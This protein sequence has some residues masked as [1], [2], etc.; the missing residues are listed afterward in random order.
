MKDFKD[1]P[2][3]V[4]G[5]PRLAWSDGESEMGVEADMSALG[6]DVR[7][8]F[9][10]LRREWNGRPL[11]YLDTASTAQKPEIVMDALADHLRRVN[12]NVHR[13]VYALAREADAAYDEA[14][15]WVAGFVGGDLATT[16]F[17]KNVTEAINL[18][19]YAWGRANIH[20]GEEVLITTM[21]HHA[22]IVPWQ[23]LC[24]E[25]GAELRYLEV[26]ERGVLDPAR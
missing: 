5:G 3:G 21:E 10:I 1:D 4:V 23:V 8:D 25:K 20:A 22:N 15:G 11:V 12:A 19:A 7:G 14:R 16:I 2:S 9:P 24:R 18:V 26:D 13:G 17:T 6:R